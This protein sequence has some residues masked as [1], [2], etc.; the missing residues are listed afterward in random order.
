MWTF[1]ICY[2]YTWTDLSDEKDVKLKLHDGI[3]KR[4]I[5]AVASAKRRGRLLPF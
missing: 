1:R 2:V 3:K 5:S 4:S